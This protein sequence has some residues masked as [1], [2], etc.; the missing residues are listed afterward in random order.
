MQYVKPIITRS[1][2]KQKNGYISK[3]DYD[4][5]IT[6]KI[7]DDLYITKFVKEKRSYKSTIEQ[8]LGNVKINEVLPFRVKFIN[9]GVTG[10]SVPPIGIAIIG[11]NNYIL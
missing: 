4:N 7:D 1:R 8:D 10:Y 6:V 11:Y 9:M 2:I 3:I 5:P